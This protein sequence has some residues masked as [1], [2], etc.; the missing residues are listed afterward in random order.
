MTLTELAQLTLTTA[1]TRQ[2]V[3]ATELHV[4]SAIFTAAPSNTGYIYIG[5]SSASATRFIKA[6]APG[7]SWSVAINVSNQGDSSYIALE[8]INWD[9]DTSGNKMNVGYMTA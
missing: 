5:S 2:A 8:S 7:E 9:A 3:S 4:E 6:L 1:T